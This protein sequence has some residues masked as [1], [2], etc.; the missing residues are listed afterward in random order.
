MR[1]ARKEA[2]LNQGQVADE[3]GINR[4]SIHS[5]ESGLAQPT[6][7]RLESVAALYGKSSA[8][9]ITGIEGLE[10]DAVELALRIGKLSA[11][12]RLALEQTL[13]AFDGGR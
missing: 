9:F 6:R 12:Q 11:D 8:W 7:S 2:G 1:A 4:R 5:W 13:D 3:L 10:W